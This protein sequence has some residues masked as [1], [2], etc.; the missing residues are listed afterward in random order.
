MIY[1]TINTGNLFLLHAQVPSF[2]KGGKTTNY[3]NWGGGGGGG[4]GGW[5]RAGLNVFMFA[6]YSMYM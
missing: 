4:G 5:G 2:V 1:T 6:V 3:E